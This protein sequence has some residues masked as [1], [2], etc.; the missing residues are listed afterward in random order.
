MVVL[1]VD[2]PFEE[3]DEDEDDDED[4]DEEDAA[5]VV[6]S[7]PVLGAWVDEDPPSVSAATGPS[8]PQPAPRSREPA[9]HQPSRIGGACPRREAAATG[10]GAGS[11]AAG[12]GRVGC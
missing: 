10:S 2:S 9:I 1:P 8:S 5:S 12:T 7:G 6:G 3:E 4:D 11:G